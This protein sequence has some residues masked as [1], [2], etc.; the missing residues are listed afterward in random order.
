MT[1]AVTRF[2][3]QLG[4]TNVN[5]SI[6]Q[7]LGETATAEDFSSGALPTSQAYTF[8]EQTGM[9]SYSER[10]QTY[11][12][13]VKGDNTDE[14]SEYFYLQLSGVNDDV[15]TIADGIGQGRIVNDDAKFSVS[16]GAAAYEGVVVDAEGKPGQYFTVTRTS[17]TV[18]REQVINWAVSSAGSGVR[19]AIGDD[20]DGGLTLAGSVTFAADSTDLTR[21]FFVPFVDDAVKELN[22]IFKVTISA[23]ANVNAADITKAVTYGTILNDAGDTP[24][25]GGSGPVAPL[26]DSTVSIVLDADG[27]GARAVEGSAETNTIVFTVART[28][29]GVPYE[30][31]VQWRLSGAANN[32]ADE[33]DF[34]GS[35]PSGTLVLPAD[36]TSIELVIDLGKDSQFEP[37]EEFTLILSSPSEGVAVGTWTGTW[38]GSAWVGGTF[39][40]AQES[41]T[42]KGVIENDDAQ[43]LVVDS[44]TALV[45]Q[46][47]DAA[48][49]MTVQ[50]DGDTTQALTVAWE[51]IPIAG[52]SVTFVA[53]SGTL[54]FAAGATSAEIALAWTDNDLAQANTSYT[55]R[56]KNPA[57]GASIDLAA[58]ERVLTLRNDD[59]D[60][61][62]I[63]ALTATQ[64][65]GDPASVD[66][67]YTDYQITISRQNPETELSGAWTVRGVGDYPI[68]VTALESATGNVEFAAGQLQATVT[69]RVRKD[70]V[71]D[72]DRT[73]T[74][75]LS[76]LEATIAGQVDPLGAEVVTPPVELTVENDDPAITVAIESVGKTFV[77]GS[78]ANSKLITFTIFRDDLTYLQDGEIGGPEGV[79]TVDWRIA[80]VI[81]NGVTSV[82]MADF[83]GFWPSGTT[84]FLDG[85]T[86]KRV[87]VAISPDMVYEST[88]AFEVHLTG[89]NS[90]LQGTR[91]LIDK[92]TDRG[93]IS[94]DDN[95]VYVS[96]DKSNVIEG[97]S[98]NTENVMFSISAEG[99][100]GQHVTVEFAL[101]GTGNYPANTEDIQWQYLSGSQVIEHS[102]DD[103]TMTGS[104]KLRISSQGTAQA[105]LWVGVVGDGIAGNDEQFRLRITSATNASIVTASAT[106]TIVNDDSLV[107]LSPV[108]I[109]KGEN[110]DGAYTDYTFTVTRTGDLSRSAVVDYALEGF[111][112]NAASDDDFDFTG[113]GTSAKSGTLTFNGGTNEAEKTITIRV[114]D[115]T[116]F[117]SDE[118]FAIRLSPGTVS[119]NEVVAEIDSS[120]SLS[121]GEIRNDDLADLLLSG[122]VT[123]VYEGSDPDAPSEL[124]YEV[125]RNGDNSQAL[126]VAYTINGDGGTDA[127]SWFVGGASGTFT[128]AAG[129]S[130]GLLVL[131]VAANTVPEADRSFSLSISA[132]GFVAPASVGGEI[133][134]DESG[135]SIAL[136]SEALAEGDSGLATYVFT[137]TRTG[138]SGAVSVGWALT[139]VGVDAVTQ[140]DFQS[141]VLP[142]GTL[143][144]AVGEMS[145]EITIEVKADAVVEADELMRVTLLSSS[146]PAQRILT[147]FANATIEN[148]DMLS[149]SGSTIETG[150]GSGMVFGGAGNDVIKGGSGSSVIDAGAGDDL[151]HAGG[152][153]DRILAGDGNDT[154]YLNADNMQHFAPLDADSARTFVDG[155]AG[156]DTVVFDVVG[157]TIDLTAIMTKVDGVPGLRNVE[158]VDITSTGAA[159]TLKLDASAL[160]LQNEDV[161]TSASGSGFKQLM[162]KGGAGDAVEITDFAGDADGTWA[163]TTTESLDN[164]D[165]KVFLNNDLKLQLLVQ[166]T[167]TA[168]IVQG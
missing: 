63:E 22:E 164:V 26:A 143:V 111:G 160:G 21:T 166:D 109:S 88:E 96:V 51:L 9:G 15:V 145:K 50:R 151:I 44:A 57:T 92:D 126:T 49:T 149:A 133:I 117:E 87:Q 28:F 72:F 130:R 42:A 103:D 12:V 32:T 4:S 3:T 116:D 142:A 161:F 17:D 41:I 102:F 79:T 129:E 104:V 97:D 78:G 60:Q 30:G 148:D 75:E 29:D 37:D 152:G 125:I 66:F 38:D 108:S 128:L 54:T 146:D 8:A 118:S 33:D 52:S 46:E 137:V 105:D 167:M 147:S 159:N 24:A 80:P 74:I 163:A 82:N 162:V 1:F 13:T 154:G 115:D 5:V 65:E 73:F 121:V 77:E 36:Q 48:A 124:V 23:G 70:L 89:F 61:L 110:E 114:N 76:D 27:M 83:G 95:G 86:F 25:Q 93:F 2:G 35:W 16:A 58:G 55:L 122:I 45:K 31:T 47:Q 43:F 138:N 132:A 34:G 98:G 157:A 101:E 107:S 119:N 85:E 120:A 62:S 134:D 90:Q 81:D 155:G 140:S 67:E 10:S 7:G 39:T 100:A 19:A 20:I 141:G 123:K 18:G 153:A 94:N 59:I 106:T 144:F 135:I 127:S 131:P 64:N 53:L 112:D 158:S 14:R 11:T 156:I 139:G 71:G 69:V 113:A 168:S 136:T 68:D 165:Y 56:L 84:T 99:I 6:A 150:D 91:I 40:P